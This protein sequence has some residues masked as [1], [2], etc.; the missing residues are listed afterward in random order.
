[1]KGKYI[2]GIAAWP[3]A[4]PDGIKGIGGCYPVR[5]VAH[6]G[7]CCLTSDWDGPELST[8]PREQ[9]VRCL[10]AH[11]QVI[12]RLMADCTVLPM[13]F[14]T[15]LGAEEEAV[16]LLQQGSTLFANALSSAQGKVELELAATWDIE[17]ALREVSAEDDIARARAAIA[18]QGLPVMEQKVRLGQ[19]VKACLDSRRETY[20]SQVMDLLKPIS[21]AVVSNALL[22]DSMVLNLAFL[23]RRDVQGEFEGR[24][25]SLDALFHG[26][27]SFRL[28]GP[29]PLYS[30]SAIEVRPLAPGEL[31]SAKRALQLDDN[32][33][34]AEVRMA[35]RRM[36]AAEIQRMAAGGKVSSPGMP[37]L[38][39]AADV[40]L[41]YCR[42]HEATD[43][44]CTE[45]TRGELIFSIDVRSASGEEIEAERF[46]ASA[47]ASAEQ[48]I[49]AHV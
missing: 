16:S 10:L 7:L 46:G 5:V 23:V 25:R 8:L 49:R 1:M 24:V 2:Y 45:T 41:R 12:E 30:F 34:A 22:S 21:V 29:M 48:G 39:Q 27:L 47:S 19:A 31:D 38:R 42:A 14:G 44:A 37:A 35:Y 40:L 26:K 20:R 9:L 17:Q 4:A 13:R 28:V 11:Q 3:I 6:D 36:A 43:K 18:S 15:V 33:S 32:I